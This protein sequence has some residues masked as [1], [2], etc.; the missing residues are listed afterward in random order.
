MES[1]E[2]LNGASTMRL[3]MALTKHRGRVVGSE[4]EIAMVL[5]IEFS[6]VLTSQQLQT[7]TLNIIMSLRPP[8]NFDIPAKKYE[9]EKISRYLAERGKASAQPFS[10]KNGK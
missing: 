4:I 2:C 3:K 9:R 10:F 6:R 7:T 1:V 8:E 5:V